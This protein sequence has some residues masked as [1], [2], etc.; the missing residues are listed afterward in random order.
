M[1]KFLKE[2]RK[3][4]KRTVCYNGKNFG[5]VRKVYKVSKIF[6]I[7]PNQFAMSKK[8]LHLKMKKIHCPK[9]FFN[10]QKFT[11]NFKKFIKKIKCLG[12]IFK[13]WDTAKKTFF[14]IPVFG[15]K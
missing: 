1:S 3:Y 6:F 11:Y 4:P 8:K 15:Q 13:L 12:Q 5:T 10:V 9:F 14:Q 7:V 2:Q